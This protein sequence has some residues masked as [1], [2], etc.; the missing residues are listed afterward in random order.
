[1]QCLARWCQRD[2]AH[3]CTLTVNPLLAGTEMPPT[4]CLCSDRQL[5]WLD[6]TRTGDVPLC[7]EGDAISRS[8]YNL[9][10]VLDGAIEFNAVAETCGVELG[11][12]RA[13]V[14]Q[15]GAIDV[16]DLVVS[17]CTVS[18][19]LRADRAV[20][21]LGGSDRAFADRTVNRTS[22]RG[23]VAIKVGRQL[24]EAVTALSASWAVP[25]APSAIS[26][27]PTLFAPSAS[28]P[29]DPVL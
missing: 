11:N 2:Q 9:V 22:W 14:G 3:E 17:N 21:E 13:A 12:W 16:G 25:T 19:L 29:I 28:E 6:V 18:K 5:R 4:V 24:V 20:S 1:M 15:L 8:R 27:D 7:I 26:L 10:G 23:C